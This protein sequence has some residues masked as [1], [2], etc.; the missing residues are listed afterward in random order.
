MDEYVVLIVGDT[1]R[2]WTTMT[3]DDRAAGYARYSEF[4]RALA[5][6]GHEVTGGAE[7]APSA[8]GRRLAGTG[9]VT[10]G[11]FAE[12]TEQV[13]GFYQIRTA[14]PDDLLD[15]CRILLTAGDGIEL[16]RVIQP[17]ERRA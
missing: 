11:P 2:W 10:D 3:A 13:G 9:E 5:E 14:D 1:D 7:L 8:G 15:C 12:V 4:E 6:R 16:R 17:E